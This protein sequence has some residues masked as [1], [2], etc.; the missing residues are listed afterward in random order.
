MNHAP[1][2]IFEDNHI[3]V[4][5]KPHGMPSQADASADL[6]LLT[7][8]KK[9]RSENENK[10]GDAFV[11]LVHR[12]DRVTGGVMVF[13]KTSKAAKRLSLQI[14]GGEQGH[15]EY[16]TFNKKYLAVIHGTPNTPQARL[17]HYLLKNEKLNKVEVVGAAIS[18][19]K[20]A[21]LTYKVLNTVDP[22]ISTE[23][24]I[25]SKK[26]SDSSPAIALQKE[27]FDDEPKSSRYDGLQGVK[28]TDAI[29]TSFELEKQLDTPKLSLVEINLLTGR[30]HQIRVQF[31]KT[32]NPLFAD[33]KYGTT[34]FPKNQHIDLALWAYELTF[35]HPTTGQ[36]LRFIVN[37]PETHPWELFE[38][39]RKSHKNIEQI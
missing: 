27:E 8:L 17:E 18:G 9:Y 15:P 38:F 22:N 5:I 7:Q 24:K 21:V 4:V 19:A 33:A 32:G 37:P 34:K 39:A 10:P 29:L 36:R 30:S 23:F 6:D 25:T 14:Q 31:A 11:G 20:R 3:I 35:N 1:A 2:I 26:E 16:G 12:L 13:A 28:L